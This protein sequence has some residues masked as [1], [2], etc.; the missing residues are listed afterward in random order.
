[1]SNIVSNNFTGF[2]V[3]PK[4]VVDETLQKVVT[5]NEN[6]DPALRVV[7][8]D[9]EPDL[10][11]I[12]SRIGEKTEGEWDNSVDTNPGSIISILKNIDSKLT[13]PIRPP[14]PP[15]QPLILTEVINDISGPVTFT[16]S[17]DQ[18][19]VRIPSGGAYLFIM[20]EDTDN[21]YVKIQIYR[22]GVTSVTPGNMIYGSNSC[23]NVDNSAV[24]MPYHL[25]WNNNNTTFNAIEVETTAG[26]G[27]LT[28]CGLVYPKSIYDFSAYFA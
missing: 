21:Y 22:S 18:A 7:C 17:S 9:V 2:Q 26:G 4:Y 23:Y 5:S 3:Y 8:N 13:T 15:P 20:A 27:T 24:F 6:G 11:E 16:K 28:Q 25:I 12:E 14:T 10:S 19:S 1:M